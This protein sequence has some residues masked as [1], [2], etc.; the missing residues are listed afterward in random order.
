MQ[1]A[2]E[3]HWDQPLDTSAHVLDALGEAA[4][5]RA[6]LDTGHALMAGEQPEQAVNR[7]GAR[8]V[9]VH[10][11]EAGL[12]TLTQRLLGRKLRK[13]LQERPPPIFPGEGALDLG[14]L[15]SQLEQIGSPA[16]SPSSTRARIRL[17]P[18]PS[19]R[20]GGRPRMTLVDLGA[21][22]GCDA[23]TQGAPIVVLLA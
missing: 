12:P 7:L 9:H 22:G 19:R 10:L 6:C 13:R 2:V 21:L 18:F 1:V 5:A 15:K 14:A 23:R 3:N 20:G 8:L 11:K 4:S 16:G 17:A